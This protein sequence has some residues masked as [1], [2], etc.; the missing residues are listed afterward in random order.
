MRDFI[1]YDVL[2]EIYEHL[3][4]NFSEVIQTKKLK[5][6][7]PLILLCNFHLYFSCRNALCNNTYLYSRIYDILGYQIN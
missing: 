2:C 6:V 4:M 7:V 1:L 5:N 3:N